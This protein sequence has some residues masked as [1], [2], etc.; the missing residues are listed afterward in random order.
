MP[1]PLGVVEVDLAVL[2]SS[3]NPV[4]VLFL[5][6]ACIFLGAFLTIRS[7]RAKEVSSGVVARS[8]QVSAKFDVEYH[9]AAT[10]MSGLEPAALDLKAQKR[11]R[12]TE[13]AREH[14]QGPAELGR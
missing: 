5:L 14:F 7:R 6:D 8:C 4:H 1:N 11:N 9:Y 12:D 3:K 2:I 10:E 13:T